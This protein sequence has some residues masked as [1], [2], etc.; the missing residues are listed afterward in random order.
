LEELKRSGGRV[1]LNHRDTRVPTE[2]DLEVVFVPPTSE[3][4]RAAFEDAS[5]VFRRLGIKA[6][7]IGEADQVAD[8][9]E[10][11]LGSVG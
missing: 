1:V 6:R 4:P 11:A 3:G 7:E 8:L 9:A 2:V 10:A 5:G